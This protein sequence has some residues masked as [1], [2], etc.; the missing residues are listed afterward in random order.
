MIKKRH[1]L[2]FIII[3]IITISSVSAIEIAK[4]DPNRHE[5]GEDFAIAFP[6][7]ANFTKDNVDNNITIYED[8]DDRI[9]IY[10][11]DDRA[12]SDFTIDSFY[13]NFKSNGTFSIYFTG[14][15]LTVFRVND[16]NIGNYGVATHY[17]CRVVI[18]C[19]DDLNQLKEI[20]NSVEFIEVIE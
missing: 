11:I 10:Y 14:E 18:I 9:T 4:P 3:F 16:S 7:N 8:A 1:Y 13:Q 6:A 20:A 12:I 17:D 19:G 15:N 5:F 2:I